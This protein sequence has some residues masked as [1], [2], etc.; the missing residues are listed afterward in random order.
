MNFSEERSSELKEKIRTLQNTVR[1]KR[2]RADQLAAT[3]QRCD[4]HYTPPTPN[5]DKSKVSG[6]YYKQKVE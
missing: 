3:L 6:K 4:F 2:D 1:S 5:F